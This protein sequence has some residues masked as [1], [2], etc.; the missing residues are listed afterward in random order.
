MFRQLSREQKIML[1]TL[2]LIN[3][4]NYVDR[5]V[6]FPLFG[7]IKKEFLVSDFQ[8]GLLGAAFMFT[9]SLA[10]VPLGILAD[11]Y[12]RKAII[13]FG[14]GFWSLMTFFSGLAANFKSLLIARSAVGLG[15]SSYGPA[16]TAMISDNVP[17]SLRARSLGWFNMGMFV[18]G[19]FGAML[20]GM[21]A[22]YADNWRAAFFVVALPGLFL[23]LW[24]LKLKD[25]RVHHQNFKPQIW[26]LF[27]NPAYVWILVSG[28]LVTFAAGA[29]ISWGI[30]YVVRFKGYSLRDASLILGSTL[31]AAGSVGVLA[32][33][34]LAD[35]A[36]SK[37]VFGRSLVVSLALIL[38]GPLMLL[39]FAGGERGVWFFV[40]FFFGTMF[41]CFYHSPSTAVMHDIVPK[42]WRASAFGFYVLIIHLFGD[43]PAPAVV[44]K[45]SD[46]VGLKTSL[47]WCTLLVFLSGLAFLAV[48][49]LIRRKKVLLE[50]EG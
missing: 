50:A 11:R 6:I 18:G 21:V 4:F 9:H 16:A 20:G 7:S 29:F 10:S 38:A 31:M 25:N 14:V 46:R 44:G 23:A 42:H 34:A 17:Q 33:S 37:F 22:F 32:G 28:C 19:T 15:E 3:F 13:S 1:G 27:K 24:S 47:A 48:S 43:T 8:L 12:S 5:Q 36:Q 39:G 35:W 49:E 45:I 26:L 40:F 30:E 41:L 2:A